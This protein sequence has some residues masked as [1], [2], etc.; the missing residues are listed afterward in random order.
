MKNVKKIA[1]ENSPKSYHFFRLLFSLQNS[2]GP[3]KSSPNGENLAQYGHPVSEIM[4]VK[5]FIV[6]S[7]GT[8]PI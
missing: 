3:L 2:P 6:Q 4:T 7:P 1:L 5:I 8:S